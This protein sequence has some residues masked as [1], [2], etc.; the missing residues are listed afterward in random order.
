MITIKDLL[1]KDS[2]LKLVYGSESLE[3]ATIANLDWFSSNSLIVLGDAKY[4][5]KYEANDKRDGSESL[6]LSQKLFESM[7]N[8]EI[9]GLKS[10]AQA[11]LTTINSAI[12]ISKI[13]HPFFQEK[14]ESLNVQVDGRKLGTAKIHPSSRIAENVFIGDNVEIGE[15][16]VI[17]SGTT[18]L[19]NCSIGDKTVV[20]P[21]VVI[22]PYTEI[23]QQCRI[24][25][26]T[27][28]GSDGFGYNYH[29]G[30]HHKIWHFGGVKIGDLVEIGSGCT[31]D[32]GTFSP[33]ILEAQTKLDNQVHV[34]HNVQL[35]PGVILC[36]QVGIAGS[37]KIGAFSVFGGQAAMADG[38]EIGQGCQVAG[39]CVITSNWEDG[40]VL[41]GHPARPLKE[42][43][44]GLAFVRK[45][46]LKK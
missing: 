34:A 25:A 37:S 18:I 13:S 30:V 10:Q 17:M 27:T 35:G 41:G 8:E 3:L 29:E 15:D 7:S 42:W 2:S 32:M 14:I 19:P 6:V 38:I 20:F 16:V 21:N 26:N 45:N 43:M 5:K 28:I 24:H 31:I 11:L 1:A 12:T 23:G 39:G 46:S 33:T 22:Y 36:G 4:L 40:A 44:R 9:E